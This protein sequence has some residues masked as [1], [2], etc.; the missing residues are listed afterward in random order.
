LIND[1]EKNLLHQ[2]ANDDHA[3]IKALFDH[4]HGSLC[5]LSYRVTRDRDLAK[6]VV[7]EVFLKL[8]KNRHQLKITVSVAAYLKRA[9]VNTSVNA[10]DRKG[11][12][13]ISLHNVHKDAVGFQRQEESE[14]TVNEL[15]AMVDRAIDGLPVRTRAVFRLI[16]F[17]DMSYQETAESLNIS[18]KAVEKE[19]MK[20]LRMLRI[21]LK[22]YLTISVLLPM[23]VPV[24]L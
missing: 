6:D 10:L 2:L 18:A 16:R 3:A 19:M 4:Y 20:A 24:W 22:D 21:A 15:Q 5:D 8:W 13:I 17:E 11:A 14:A 1:Q 9:V 7:Q 23:L 12:K